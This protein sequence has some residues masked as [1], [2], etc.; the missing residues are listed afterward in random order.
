MCALIRSPEN[1]HK[2]CLVFKL[3]TFFFFSVNQGI[4][5]LEKEAR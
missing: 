4:I 5:T 2:H 3:Y 1:P